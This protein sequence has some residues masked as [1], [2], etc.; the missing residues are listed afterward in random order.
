MRRQVHDRMLTTLLLLGLERGELLR[1][2][3]VHVLRHAHHIAALVLLLLL[4]LNGV[5]HHTLLHESRLVLLHG[6]LYLLRILPRRLHLLELLLLQQLL[7]RRHVT[8]CLR[9]R[10]TARHALPA[11][12]LARRHA[13][14]VLSARHPAHRPVRA[15]LHPHHGARLADVRLSG[16]GHAGL[17]HRLAHVLHVG[18]DARMT[19]GGHTR[20][21]L[22]GGLRLVRH[23]LLPPSLARAHPVGGGR[24]VRSGATRPRDPSHAHAG[25]YLRLPLPRRRPRQ[26]LVAR[27]RCGAGREGAVVSPSDNALCA[28]SR[29]GCQAA[30]ALHGVAVAQRQEQVAGESRAVR[31]GAGASEGRPQGPTL[32]VDHHSLTPRLRVPD[33]CSHRRIQP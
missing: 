14:R 10:R 17:H 1:G 11:H 6:Q 7:L 16:P 21:L 22:H 20:M 5:L 2:D 25:L 23:H 13:T 24:R 30:V 18:R 8:E 28:R 15:R 33:S 26:E 3:V 12:A 4:L 29:S 32:C 19:V 27:L 31:R 9:I